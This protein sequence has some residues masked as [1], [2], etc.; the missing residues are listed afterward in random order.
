MDREKKNDELKPGISSENEDAAKEP[1]S[2]DP[3]G[4]GEELS[5]KPRIRT[6]SPS[7]TNR[8]AI[9]IMVAGIV[10]LPTVNCVSSK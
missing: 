5:K 1:A 7:Q 8:N 4:G 2:L 9:P 3:S 10:V 6:P